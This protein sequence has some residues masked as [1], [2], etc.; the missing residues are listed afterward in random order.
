MTQAQ[1]N[2]EVHLQILER[3]IGEPDLDLADRLI[4]PDFKNHRTGLQGAVDALKIR[5]SVGGAEVSSLEG[6]KRGLQLIRRSFPDW[7]HTPLE[8]VAEGDLVM[9]TWRL[10][11]TFTG[12]PFLGFQARGQRVSKDEAGVMRFRDGKLVEFWGLSDTLPFLLQ[13]GARLL[14]PDGTQRGAE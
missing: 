8:T 11:A 12:E 13:L 14:L 6:F 2:K 7:H 4:A 5:R 3:V 9:G 1:R 10:S